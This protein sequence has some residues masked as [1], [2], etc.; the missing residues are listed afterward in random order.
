MSRGLVA[1][2]HVPSPAIEQGERTHRPRL[3][4]DFDRAC[5]QHAAYRRLLAECGCEVHLLTAN[6]DFPD[7]VFLEDTAVV[8]DEVAVL[9]RMG[10]ASRR[11]EPAGIEPAIARYRPI[12]RLAAPATL[13]GGDVLRV[14]RTLLVGHSRRT[15]RAGIAALAEIAH[16]HGYRVRPVPVRGCLHL[17]S[18]CAALP[19]GRLLANPA[20]LDREAL[21]DF[22]L[23]PAPEAEAANALVVGETLLLAAGFPRTEALVRS[24]GFDVRTIDLSEFAKAE[25][26]V[27]CL[28]L[29]V[30][31]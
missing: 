5:R 17:K 24:L 1:L 28:S 6:R 20:A 16:R 3:P 8:L 30:P 22:A 2:T 14:G 25:G 15:N 12:C 9:S 11:G 10:V 4:I 19:D 27:T 18:A 13:E 23:V 7:G 26:A 31:P 29:I 21:A